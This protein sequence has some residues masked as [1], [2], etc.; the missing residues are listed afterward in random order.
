MR[1]SADCFEAVVYI[2]LCIITNIQSIDGSSFAFLS[3]LTTNS[4]CLGST[5][6]SGTNTSLASLLSNFVMLILVKECFF[7]NS[8]N[9]ISGLNSGIKIL[10]L[11]YHFFPICSHA[12]FT[13]HSL[14]FYMIF[15]I[16]LF[17]PHSIM[18]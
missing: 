11:E 1:N 15:L 6:I 3:S 9:V 17:V 10:G 14:C 13:V 7:N 4:Y 8:P 18:L 5:S 2:G 16:L 12:P